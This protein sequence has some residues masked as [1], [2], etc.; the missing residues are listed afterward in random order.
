MRSLVRDFLNQ[1]LSRLFFKAMAAAGFTVAAAESVLQDLVPVAHA[2][3]AGRQYVKAFE[4]TAE[5]CW[6][7]S[8]CKPASTICLSA[9][10]RAWVRYAMRSLTGPDSSLF[11]R[12]MRLTSWPWPAVIR[13]PRAKL[14][15]VCTAGWGGAHSTGNIYNAMKDRLPIV[16]AVDRADTTEDGR[17]GHEDLE[18]MLE[19]MKQY[20]K[21]RWVSKEVGRIPEWVTKAFKVSSTMPCGPTYLMFPRDVTFEHKGKGEHFSAGHV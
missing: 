8:C 16:V 20:T 15:S 17:D 7:S 6:P 3:T 18:D 10:A 2:Q 1:D 11:W 14:P 4:G 5:S 19:P 9:T 12:P 21:W 13:W